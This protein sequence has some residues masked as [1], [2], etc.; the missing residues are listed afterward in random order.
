MSQC[1]TLEKNKVSGIGPTREH[2]NNQNSKIIVLKQKKKE[3]IL[4]K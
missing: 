4:I 3:R 1:L 2:L